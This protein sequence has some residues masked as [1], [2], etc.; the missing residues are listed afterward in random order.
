MFFKCVVPAS[1]LYPGGQRLQE[2]ASVDLRW[3]DF[4]SWV[5]WQRQKNA[6]ISGRKFSFPSIFPLV[7]AVSIEYSMWIQPNHGNPE[8]KMICQLFHILGEPVGGE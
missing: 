2:Y 7:K 4:S 1:A 6:A 8:K 5:L 3:R